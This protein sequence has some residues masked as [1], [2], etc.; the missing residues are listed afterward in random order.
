M[1]L[2]TLEFRSNFELELEFQYFLYFHVQ[3]TQKL[4]FPMLLELHLLWFQ[5]YDGILILRFKA[6][7]HLNQMV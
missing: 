4:L 3:A 6:L 2:K 7:D 5:Q 1:K